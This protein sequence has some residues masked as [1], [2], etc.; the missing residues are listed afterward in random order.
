MRADD[1]V[2]VSMLGCCGVCL[3]ARSVALSP[4]PRLRPRPLPQA[5]EV[6]GSAG[7]LF[8]EGFHCFFEA[9]HDSASRGVD[10]SGGL[11]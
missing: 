5:G 10:G 11:V 7:A 2:L 1:C 8:A 9:F 4:L 3:V 6:A